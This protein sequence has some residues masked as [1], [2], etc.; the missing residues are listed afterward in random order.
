MKLNSFCNVELCHKGHKKC[1]FPP[2]LSVF[3][4]KTG[5]S[6]LDLEPGHKFWNQIHVPVSATNHYSLDRDKGRTELQT[7]SKA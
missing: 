5:I 3:N 4:A 2:I 6:H 1:N 7:H